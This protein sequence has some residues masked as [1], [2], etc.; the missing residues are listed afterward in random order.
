MKKKGSKSSFS[1]LL[2]FTGGSGRYFVMAILT[3]AASI[4]LNFLTPQVVGVTVDSVIGTEPFA[5]P[6]FLLKIMESFGG[7]EF[8][9]N[10]LIIC[11]IAVVVCSVSSGIFNYFSRMNI[12][13]GTEGFTKKLR[14]E[15]FR[16]TQYL[17]FSWHTE[18]K[19]GD[20]IQRC[21]ADV[22]TARNFISAQL[23][24]VIRTVILISM[25]MVIMFSMNWKL[26]LVALVFIPIVLCYTAF[27]YSRISKQ[28][29]EA[30]ETEGRLMVQA[31][32]NFTG[33]RVVRAFGREMYEREQFS[34]KNDEFAKSWIDL[35]YTLG[36]YWGVG[37]IVSASQL[38]V[39]IAV[40]AYMAAGGHMTLGQLL[41]FISYTQTM[42]WPVRNLGHT[43]SEMSKTGVSLKRLKEILDAPAEEKD[44]KALTPPMDRDIE[45]KNVSFS[46]GDAQVLRDVSFKVESGTTFGILGSTGSG[47]S[48]VTYLLN[49]LYDLPEGSG[50]ITIGGVNINS[51]DRQYLR[52]NVGLVLQEP[53]LFSKT[54][55]E[56]IAITADSAD[57]SEIRRNAGVA[58]VDDN[59]ME[60]GKG[61]DTVVGERGVTLS[62]GQKQRIAI[63]RTLETKAPIMV[64]DD[65]MSAV[66]METDAKIRESLRENT[67][68]ATVILISHRISTLMKCD[69]ILVMDG[70]RAV[71]TGT[72][73][74]LLRQNGIYKRVY[75]IQS[76]IGGEE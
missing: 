13:R 37:D 3:A 49:R 10:N 73:Q 23:I 75:D 54:I 16:H 32:E 56:N 4:F 72:H 62:G 61:Y 5:V 74:E 76:G 29:L 11:G 26:A 33:V 51:I 38:L 53:Y 47:K 9:R 2:K 27:F 44:P 7:R 66:D 50:E 19:T 58:A 35:G 64:F 65:S 41:V 20:I 17:P 63:A 22:E 43:L 40:G 15:L 45:F 18:N 14:D 34:R 46:Y 39:I 24:D 30:D 25:A 48:T 42:A 57:M 28:F 71:E 55:R 69:K 70:G 1:M 68:N 60:F 67:G 21:T 8:L 6:G 36:V 52:R 59:I 31:Q 12:A